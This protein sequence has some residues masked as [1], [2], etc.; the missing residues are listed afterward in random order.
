MPSSPGC[1]DS[2]L[3]ASLETPTTPRL[4]T[5]GFIDL[6]AVRQQAI[7]EYLNQCWPRSLLPYGVTRPQ[8][9][10]Q[11]SCQSKDQLKHKF[12]N[13]FWKSCQSFWKSWQSRTM[14]LTGLGSTPELE[15]ELGPIPT[16]TPELE[17]KSLEL[18]LELEL[19]FRAIAGVKVGVETPGVGVGIDIP[20][21]CRSWSWS[22]NPRSWSWSWYSGV[23]PRGGYSLCDGWYICA[24]VLTPFFHFG[25]I[26]HDLFGVFLHPPTAKLSFGVQKLPIFTKIDLFG[27]KF[28]FFL[29]LFG[30][31]FQRPAA[32]PH[33]FS[34]RVPPPGSWPQPWGL[35]SI[36]NT[37]F[38]WWLP[39]WCD[40]NECSRSLHKMSLI[41]YHDMQISWPDSGSPPIRLLDS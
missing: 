21:N 18:E 17:L 11:I 9:V 27:P 37:G 25:R 8:W 29:D 38:G 24:A 5:R 23:D 7:T 20:G 16:P 40:E 35:T 13:K 2:P 1:R 12:M 41:F 30:S 31:N 10:N 26:E 6:G 3:G 33:Q 28:N 15:L 4:V 34:G 14:G 36:F 19:I 22:W 32:H 39:S